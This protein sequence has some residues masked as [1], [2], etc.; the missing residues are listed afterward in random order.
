M[1][2]VRVCVPVPLLTPTRVQWSEA[3]YHRSEGG[4]QNATPVRRT[5][6]RTCFVVVVCGCCCR[7]LWLLL[8]SASS[9]VR[10]AAVVV[11]DHQRRR[12]FF[13]TVTHVA[14]AAA[15]NAQQT[16][17]AEAKVGSDKFRRAQSARRG[18]PLYFDK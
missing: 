2:V 17:S 3:G 11:V 9:V 15:R 10:A 16:K 1:L 5:N 13:D 7:R 8:S 12:V 6:E 18:S 14:M 4:E